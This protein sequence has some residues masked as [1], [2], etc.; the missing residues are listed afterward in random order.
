MPKDSFSFYKPDV[1]ATLCKE[2][3]KL[4][5]TNCVKVMALENHKTGSLVEIW[6]QR[7][8]GFTGDTTMYGA[9]GNDMQ[10]ECLFL[11]MV[12]L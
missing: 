2:T 8:I 1:H 11:E 3:F 6:E 7:S 9:N 5:I 10:N 12:S 4:N